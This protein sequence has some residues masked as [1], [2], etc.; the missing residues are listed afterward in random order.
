MVYTL[1]QKAFDFARIAH[2]TIGQMRKHG[3]S[4]QPYI[5]HPIRVAE[6]I[7]TL[8]AP[9]QSIAA[10]FLHDTVE[11]VPLE[12]LKKAAE[13][14]VTFDLDDAT[15]IIYALS[16]LSE[17]LDERVNR[18]SRLKLIEIVFDVR[19]AEL[20]EMVTDVSIKADGNR[21]VRKAID[22]DH[23]AN[24]DAEGQTIKLADLIDNGSGIAGFDRGFAITWMKEK[25][26]LLTVL[27]K[28]D[29]RLYDRAS[30]M[31]ETFFS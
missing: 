16:G 25:R 9:E 19:T 28:G 13:V 20:V 6:I 8:G 1:E 3:D 5:V 2:G 30:V 29:Q 18:L 11:D 23:L 12:A 24:A 4:G 27:T 15:K 14:V 31:V 17:G 22:R 10:S 7:K 26:D 21:K